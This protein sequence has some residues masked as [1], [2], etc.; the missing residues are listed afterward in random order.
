[1]GYIYLTGN[2]YCNSSRYCEYLCDKSPLTRNSQ[3]ISRAYRILAHFLIAGI[4]AIVSF[5][6]Q[7]ANTSVFVVLVVFLMSLF[8]GTFFISLHADAAESVQI[9]F[10]MDEYFATQ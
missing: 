5:F 4:V 10:M 7:G 8:I 2:P 9:I 1:M 3:S 6:L